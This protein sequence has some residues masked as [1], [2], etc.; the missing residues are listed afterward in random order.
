MPPFK[1]L[2]SLGLC[3]IQILELFACSS[4]TLLHLASFNT[5]SAVMFETGSCLV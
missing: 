2:F 4:P 3:H 1:I 5:K